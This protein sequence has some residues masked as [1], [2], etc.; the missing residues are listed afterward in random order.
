M[1]QYV[2]ENITHDASNSV[3]YFIK[4]LAQCSET[5]IFMFLGLSTV[6][7]NH[8]FDTV[9]VVTTLVLCL[10]YRVIGNKQF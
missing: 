7:S 6:S 5:V 4:M 8:H 2:K 3:K 9:F 1:K 10:I